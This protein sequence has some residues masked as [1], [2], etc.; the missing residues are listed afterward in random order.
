VLEAAG[1]VDKADALADFLGGC[2]AQCSAC[3][4]TESC[5][6]RDTYS[7]LSSLPDPSTERKDEKVKA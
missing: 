5:T 7:L 2:D 3:P 4:R 6:G 1:K